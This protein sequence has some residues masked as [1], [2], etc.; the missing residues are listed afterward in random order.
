[1]VALDFSPAS[2]A[3]DCSSLEYVVNIDHYN[4]IANGLFIAATKEYFIGQ[5]LLLIVYRL[6]LFTITLFFGQWYS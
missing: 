5:H 4:Y 2:N 1:M 6:I 3:F